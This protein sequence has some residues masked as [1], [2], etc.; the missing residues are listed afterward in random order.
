[1]RFIMYDVVSKNLRTYNIY[2]DKNI[3][4][5]F[6][7]DSERSEETDGFT[8]AFIFIYLFFLSSLQNFY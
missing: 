5:I 6:F 1:M 7:L 3:K 2:D 8:M 4:I